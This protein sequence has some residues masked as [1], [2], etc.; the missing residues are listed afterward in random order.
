[1]NLAAFRSRAARVSGMSTTDSGDL[2]LIDAWVNDSIE[3]FLKDT[4]LNVLTA[5][6][7]VTAGQAPPSHAAQPSGAHDILP[8][9]FCLCSHPCR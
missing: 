5:S 8:S 6:L 2:A 4:K 7:A 3:Q 9:P 1:M